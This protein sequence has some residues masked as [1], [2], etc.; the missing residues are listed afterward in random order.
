MQYKLFKIMNIKRNSPHALL[1]N[2]KFKQNRLAEHEKKSIENQNW[3]L[4]C[5][6]H[7]NYLKKKDVSVH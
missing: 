1:D 7:C 2:L 4:S 5:V 3:I 6:H